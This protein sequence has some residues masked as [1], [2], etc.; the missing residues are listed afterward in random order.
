MSKNDSIFSFEQVICSGSAR[1]G[2]WGH[3]SWAQGFGGATTHFVV[4]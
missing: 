3:S 2:T 1:K 4:K